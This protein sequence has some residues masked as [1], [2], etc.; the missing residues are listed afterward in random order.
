[1]TSTMATPRPTSAAPPA[2]R[3]ARWPLFGAAAG[4]SAFG[5]VVASIPS[6]DDSERLSG[7][8][9][10]E[11]L[12]A[13]PYR[14]AFLLGLVSVGCLL[15]A[16]AGWRRWA[17][18]RAPRDLGARLIGMGLAAT[19]TVNV[20]FVGLTGALGLYLSGGVEAATMSNDALFVYHSMLD[21]GTLLGW[22]GAAV[23]AIAMAVVAFGRRGVLPR[24]MGVVSVVCLVPPVGF[25]VATS[26]PGFIGLTMP[27]WLVVVS[28]GAIRSRT[29]DLAA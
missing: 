16:A 14:I 26:L 5:A 20:V 21:F 8:P 4:I 7:A 24:W 12:D 22:W 10:V 25:A 11:T 15:T 1:V 19:A 9:V 23:S 27:I 17:E 29:A 6:L 28:V 3:R 2:T 18:A 13:A